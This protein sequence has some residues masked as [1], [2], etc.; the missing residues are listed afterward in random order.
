[1]LPTPIAFSSTPPLLLPLLVFVLP[2]SSLLPA[3][4]SVNLVSSKEYIPPQDSFWS[5]E[6]PIVMALGVQEHPGLS[7]HWEFL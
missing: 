5:C 6:G 3:S 2:T 7:C 4:H 1:M